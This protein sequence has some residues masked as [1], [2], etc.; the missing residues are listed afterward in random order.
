MVRRVPPLVQ[1]SVIGLMA[2][3]VLMIT[4]RILVPK[5]STVTTVDQ[6]ELVAIEIEVPQAQAIPAPPPPSFG[7]PDPN[8]KG[9]CGNGALG[10]LE[11]LDKIG[12]GITLFALKA[13]NSTTYVRVVGDLVLVAQSYYSHGEWTYG[14]MSRSEFTNAVDIA[15]GGRAPGKIATVLKGN[16][17]TKTFD[18]KKVE[19]F[20]KWN[21]E[22]P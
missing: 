15:A 6:G 10:G 2:L 1:Y 4:I 17:F 3:I 14:E 11:L 22:C 21:G 16:S 20:L 12:E 13:N 5:G 9:H 19:E 7:P 18:F 8:E